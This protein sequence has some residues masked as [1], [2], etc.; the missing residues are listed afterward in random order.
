MDNFERGREYL[1]LKYY[2]NYF[3]NRKIKF[4]IIFF[5]EVYTK[6]YLRNLQHFVV[7]FKCM[8]TSFSI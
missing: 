6:F 3:R 7:L 5:E 1:T 8:Y 2:I 4:C